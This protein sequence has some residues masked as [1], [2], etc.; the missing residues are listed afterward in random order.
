VVLGA[1]GRSSKL[2][3]TYLR[4]P[5][6]TIAASVRGVAAQARRTIVAT[7]IPTCVNRSL[8]ADTG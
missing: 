5:D 4:P 8:E 7:A 3:V 1:P 6:L 2:F